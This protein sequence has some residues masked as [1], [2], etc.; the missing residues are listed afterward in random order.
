LEP[1]I[2]SVEILQTSQ[3]SVH[4]RTK[5]NFTNPT[6]YSATIPLVDVLLLFNGTALAHLTAQDVVVLP[7][8]N[9]G[10]QIDALWNPLNLGG[11]AGIAAGQD[12]MSQYV[13]GQI[14]LVS[15]LSGLTDAIQ[16]LIP[17]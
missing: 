17:R 14:S 5:I 9:A 10:V 8:V 16:D 2:E 6:E 4:L 12:L 15:L 3:S 1:K 13:S 7:G 11:D